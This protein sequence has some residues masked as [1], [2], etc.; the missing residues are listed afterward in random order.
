MKFLSRDVRQLHGRRTNN[1]ERKK[2]A[3]RQKPRKEP[4]LLRTC[5]PNTPSVYILPMMNECT[6]AKEEYNE[7]GGLKRK[8][9]AR[10]KSMGGSCRRVPGMVSTRK[11][12]LS[13]HE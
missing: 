6:Q 10:A 11:S 12:N 5:K 9:C 4:T 13:R 8:K 7:N 1:E 2:S 3:Y